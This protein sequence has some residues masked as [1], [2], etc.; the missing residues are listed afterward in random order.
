MKQRPR[1]ATEKLALLSLCDH[2]NK[3]TGRCDP[4]M[5]RIA[6]EALCSKRQAIRC[7]ESLIAQGFI[8]AE[9]VNG[10]RTRYTINADRT[11]DTHD[12]GSVRA[13]SDAL[14][15][16]DA[17]DTGDTHDTPTGDT[18]DTGGVTPVSPESGSNQEGNREGG[19]LALVPPAPPKDPKP[20][21]PKFDQ[22]VIDLWHEFLPE[23]PEVRA[24]SSTEQK[25]LRA[26]RR[27]YPKCDDPDWWRRCFR[28]VRKSAFLMGE[29]EPP[30]G[31]RPF[32]LTL[33]W[34]VKPENF[35]KVVNREYHDADRGAA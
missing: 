21:I 34:L 9:K 24:W 8:S 2:H 27:E 1:T 18:H 22:T 14:V 20:A 25:N 12:T 23:L 29:V 6:E 3:S 33:R 35:A 31:R 28:F 15:T 16:G 10:A 30:E 7:I 13:T 5:A 32:R 26:R 11:G 19:E 4:S 17:G